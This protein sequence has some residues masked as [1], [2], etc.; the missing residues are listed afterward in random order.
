M[1]SVPAS[2]TRQD[3]EIK[4]HTALLR[5][6][7]FNIVPNTVNVTQEGA[8]ARKVDLKESDE[9]YNS[10]RLPQVSDT[11]MAGWGVPSVMFKELVSSTPHVQLHPYN[12]RLLR[13]LQPWNI[14]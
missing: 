1:K 12:S 9:V 8:W 14:W 4:T 6:D 11:L 2:K 5:D 13:G 10:Q 3:Q 7:I